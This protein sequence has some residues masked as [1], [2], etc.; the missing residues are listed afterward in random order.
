M[1]EHP[2]LVFD[3]DGV[4][5][6]GMAEYWWS[7]WNAAKSLNAEPPGFSPEQVPDLFRRLRPWIHHGWEMVLLAAELSG[8]DESAWVEGYEVQQHA[9]LLRRGWGGDLLQDALDRA[10]LQAVQQD[11]AAW[12]RLHRPFP[13]LARRLQLLGEEGLDWAVLTTKSEAFTAEL[14]NAFDLRPAKLDGRE[15]GPKP[16]VLLRLQRERPLRGFVEDRR[17]TLETVLSTEGLE[18]LPCYL[19]DW[20]YLKPA[21]RNQLPPGIQLIDLHRLAKPLA[22]WP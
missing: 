18:G 9:A 6:D 11:R 2:L 7:S 5:V 15:A 14:L 12:L 17:A 10:R 16:E 19:V 3:F 4:I 20:G 22:Q 8:L 21:D 13:G 1:Q